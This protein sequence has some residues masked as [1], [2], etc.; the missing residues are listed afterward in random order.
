[1]IQR[2]GWWCAIVVCGVCGV[3][4]WA[5]RAEA[6][7]PPADCKALEAAIIASPTSVPTML[8]LGT[9]NE[10]RGKL[11]T[12]IRWFRKAQAAA[13][14]AG[15]ADADRTAK[16]HALAISRSIPVLA[17]TVEGPPG[18]TIEIDGYTIDAGQY[19]NV[20]L[21][22]GVHEVVGR[23]P[24]KQAFRAKVTL[25]VAAQDK[26]RVV[27]TEAAH[28]IYLDRGRG[29]RR[30][31]VV[32]GV[33]GTLLLAATVTFSLFEKHQWEQQ[34]DPRQQDLI[35]NRVRYIGGFGGVLSLATIATGIVL[36]VT[37]PD[38][39]KVSDGTVFAPV[40]GDGNYGFELSGRF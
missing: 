28:P 25:E 32:V 10:E 17:L 35:K 12:A 3:M 40:A 38:R 13:T 22:P 30:A 1:M 11:A 9:C 24:G 4:A 16:Q 29:R 26:L 2:A 20:E 34:M 31:G 36:Y 33:A 8:E 37:A 6:G 39:E 15:L 18:T 27:V 19:G 21:D 23:A 7:G 5:P 14:E